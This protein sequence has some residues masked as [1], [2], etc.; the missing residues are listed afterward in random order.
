MY[1]LETVLGVPSGFEFILYKHGPF[2]FD[3]R[4][5]LGSLRTD[6]FIEWELKSERYRPSLKR[7]RF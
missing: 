2:S 5:E 6:G 3:L 7:N 1:I 4:D